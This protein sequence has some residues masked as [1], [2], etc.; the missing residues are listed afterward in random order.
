MNYRKRR[1]EL[2]KKTKELEEIMDLY[3]KTK[4]NRYK[5]LWLQRL[6]EV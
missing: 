5:K 1:K 3:N 4:I 2:I 6:S